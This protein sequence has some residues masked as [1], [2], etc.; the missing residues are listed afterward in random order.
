MTSARAVATFDL[1]LALAT[2]AVI[3]WG[4]LVLG[5]SP[6]VVMLL[7]WFE[8]VVIGVFNVG[9]MLATGL[10]LGAAGLLGGIALSA[11]FTVHYGIFT[12]VHGM[13]VA[14]LFGGAEVSR[15]AMDG[16]LAGPLAAMVNYLFAERDGWLAV[17]AIVLVHLSGFVQWL[18]RTRE[19]PPPLKELMGAPY[20]RIMIL[21]VTLIASGFL[22]QALK[23][24]VAGAL[25]LVGLKLA[26]DLV[27]LR[28]DRA[29]EQDPVARAGA[30]PPVGDRTETSR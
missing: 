3:A 2:A 13:F 24:P 20:G 29:K 7:F 30:R 9:K 17:L 28:R 11:F 12:A 19:A 23:S 22:V 10:R 16:G 14:L 1:A 8:N 18:A 5:W 4:V 21:H 26:Y 25:L 6:F 15:G 27:T